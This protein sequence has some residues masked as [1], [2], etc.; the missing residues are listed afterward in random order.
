MYKLSYVVR[1]TAPDEEEL[2][3]RCNA[4]RDFYDDMNV[5]LVRPVGDMI[6]LHHE[7]I[8]ASKRYMNDYIQYVTSDF[9]AGLGFGAAQMLG[10]KDG[11]YLAYGVDTGRNVYLQPRLRAR[12]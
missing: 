11:I 8:P 4:V 5:K 9:L 7:F 2:K 6:G 1:V 3:R 10:E 12:A